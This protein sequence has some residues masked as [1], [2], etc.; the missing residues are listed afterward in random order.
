MDP[1]AELK[2]LIGMEPITLVSRGNV[3]IREALV[4]VKDLHPIRRTILIPDCGG[5]LTYRTEPKKH[6]LDIV[7]LKTYDGVFDLDDL[8][9]KSKD[10]LALLYAQPAG[11]FAMQDA[12]EIYHA[13]QDNGCRVILDVTRS[14]GNGVFGS[15]DLIVGSFGRWKPVN[16]GHGGFIAGVAPNLKEDELFDPKYYDELTEK[17]YALPDRLS[18]LKDKVL[19]VKEDLVGFDIIHPKMDGLNVVVAYSDDKRR[20]QIVAY[21][22]NKGLEYTLCPRYIRV[23]RKAV[24]IE[25]KRL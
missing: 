6:G 12:V 7:E 14:I 25:L 4:S 18:M 22:E 9:R 15:A 23:N 16:L 21:C 24:S 19:K 1:K 11:Y 3:A 10:A 20:E 8:K 2:Q 17:L 5:W 13:C